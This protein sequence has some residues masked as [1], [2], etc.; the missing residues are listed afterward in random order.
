MRARTGQGSPDSRRDD[1]Y[2]TALRL[3]RGAGWHLSA[4]QSMV[5]AAAT[6]PEEL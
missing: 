4:I 1:G 6:V 2:D 3:W 5:G